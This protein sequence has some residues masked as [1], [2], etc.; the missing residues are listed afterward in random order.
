M[1]YVAEI[2]IYDAQYKIFWLPCHLGMWGGSHAM[3]YSKMVNGKRSTSTMISNLWQNAWNTFWDL[4]KFFLKI[5]F[6]NPKKCL[7][8][9]RC[10]LLA[11]FG[12]LWN[13]FHTL[14]SMQYLPRCVYLPQ[15]FWKKNPHFCLFPHTTTTSICSSHLSQCS[16]NH[17]FSLVL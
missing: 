16:P 6:L 12:C 4:F 8:F 15:I 10:N 2:D 14:L 13:D 1:A 17:Q 11:S 5:C 7:F 3:G 9:C